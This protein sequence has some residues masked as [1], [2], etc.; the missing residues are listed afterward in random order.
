MDKVDFSFDNIVFAL[1]IIWSLPCL[2]VIE[3]FFRVFWMGSMLEVAL[4]S[5]NP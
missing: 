1:L 4:P 3:P 2:S 5:D